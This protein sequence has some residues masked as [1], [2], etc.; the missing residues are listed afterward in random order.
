MVCAAGGV[1]RTVALRP[2]F[3]YGEED[4]A[5]VPGLLK[6]A[7][8]CDNTLVQVGGIGNR[9]QHAYVG[10]CLSVITWV[11]MTSYGLSQAQVTAK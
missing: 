11:T 9:Q 1:L 10:E 4:H 8:L 6:M 3:M 7:K 2:P 5:L